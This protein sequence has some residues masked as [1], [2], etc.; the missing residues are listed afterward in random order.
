M[1]KYV[2]FYC[3]LALFF[4]NFGAWAA[5]TWRVLDVLG[6][7]GSSSCV[8]DPK[9]PLCAI[10]TLEFC[11]KGGP[12]VLCRRVGIL[13]GDRHP[14]ASPDYFRLSYHR[15][16]EI[17]R[18]VVRRADIPPAQK[19]LEELPSWVEKLP[20]RAG[21]LAILMKWQGCQPDDQC[22]M[23]TINDPSKP[24]GVGCRTFDY[25]SDVNFLSRYILRRHGDE[26]RVLGFFFDPV[27]HGKF[28]NRK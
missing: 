2:V 23:D 26:W 18:G 17:A 9:T 6:A 5:E 27:F 15:Y 22:V 14:D 3:F 4:T 12:R 8:G 1:P 21:D 28:W 16:R 7:A 25:C 19:A 11:F 13:M 20:V 24:Y 10:E